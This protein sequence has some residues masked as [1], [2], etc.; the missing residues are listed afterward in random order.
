[1]AGTPEPLGTPYPAELAESVTARGGR[2]FSL[3]PI[4]PSD[5][6]GLV[7]FHEG[8]SA[9]S[10]YRR[11]FGFHPHLSAEEIAHFTTVDY[12]GR[13][14]LVVLDGDDIVGVGRYERLSGGDT[15]EVAFVIADSCQH[16]GLGTLLLEHLAAIAWRKG[17]RAF[18][19]VTLAENAD[20]LA[21]FT[22]SGFPVTTTIEGSVVHVHFPIEPT[23][24]Y[25]AAQALRRS[26]AAGAPPRC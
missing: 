3:R 23:E 25:R 16:C 4:A 17:I 22:D 20:M 26:G 15:A 19:A 2:R 1:M 8:V 13:M 18:D 11:F 10:V 6:A 5:A 9:G 12:E 7:A 14:A 21:V 24:A